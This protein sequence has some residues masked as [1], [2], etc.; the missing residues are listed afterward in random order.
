MEE[1]KVAEEGEKAQEEKVEEETEIGDGWD[2]QCDPHSGSDLTCRFRP[3]AKLAGEAAASR[4]ERVDEVESRLDRD[5][6]LSRVR[7]IDGTDSP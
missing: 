1:G 3:T 6:Q 4:K 7:D 2:G 5:G